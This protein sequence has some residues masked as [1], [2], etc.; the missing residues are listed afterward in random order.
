[1]HI[2]Q[3]DIYCDDCVEEIKF[4][5]PL[6]EEGFD[7]DDYPQRERIGEVDCPLHCGGC[8]KFLDAPL[9]GDGE[10]YVKNAVNTALE[11]QK[12][13]CAAYQVWRIEYDYLDFENWGFCN[14]CD[15]WSVLDCF[16][17]CEN[18]EDIE[19]ELLLC[20]WR[21][22]YMPTD[23]INCFDYEAWHIDEEVA[24]YLINNEPDAYLYYEYWEEVL[25]NAYY[26]DKHGVKW[27]LEQEGDLWAVSE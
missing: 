5:L 11:D 22:V 14:I 25:N 8:G 4:G 12:Y 19:K 13:D 1:M 3:G 9:T 10:E 18:C 27:H 21:G 2:F 23:F 16:D 24:D 6:P 7:S 20:D 26:I 15:D 17:K